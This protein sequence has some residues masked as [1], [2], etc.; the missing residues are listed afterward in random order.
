MRAIPNKVTVLVDSREKR[1]PKFPAN[2]RYVDDFGRTHLIHIHTESA[3]LDAGDYLLKEYPDACIIERKGS[4]RE[5][6]QNMLSH[7][8]KRMR[9]AI[10][11]LSEACQMPLLLMET[12][13]RSFFPN[14]PADFHPTE[15][16]DELLR[17]CLIRG[18]S[19][20]MAGSSRAILTRRKLAAFIVHT[21]VSAALTEEVPNETARSRLD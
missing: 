12:S 7:D 19:I 20:I 17:L 1:P 2:I 11:R 14:D 18:V 13:I 3:K 15:A 9:A 4:V 16:L 6:C 8:R 21:L 10:V 5:I